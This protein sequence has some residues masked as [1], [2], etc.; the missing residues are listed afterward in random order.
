[1]TAFLDLVVNNTDNKVK[2]VINNAYNFPKKEGHETQ[3]V[4]T[5]NGEIHSNAEFGN[6]AFFK[7]GFVKERAFGAFNTFNVLTSDIKSVRAGKVEGDLSWK[8]AFDSREMYKNT[9]KSIAA[10]L[11]TAVLVPFYALAE[12]GNRVYKRPQRKQ[13]SIKNFAFGT[14]NFFSDLIA[15][16]FVITAT[17]VDVALTLVYDAFKLVT[18]FITHPAHYY[19]HAKLGVDVE[20]P[21]TESTSNDAIK[22]LV[23]AKAAV[24]KK[25]QENNLEVKFE[26]KTIAEII[27]SQGMSA[28]VKDDNGK[29][30]IDEITTTDKAKLP[31]TV[32]D[33]FTKAYQGK[34][35]TTK[36]MRIL[37][38]PTTD[39]LFKL[40]VNDVIHNDTLMKSEVTPKGA[41][42]AK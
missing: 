34:E 28:T 7:W 25:F 33:A 27:E 21:S 3:P 13:W 23:K 2:S 26:D 15:M 37:I 11:I 19:A 39:S 35:N 30:I 8:E 31:I 10:Q 38:K 24:Y 42:A 36:N 4:S 20:K 12:L 18:G 1:M 16:A 14:A 41:V 22:A 5:L 9:I 17:Y 40:N 6:E 32:V 29:F